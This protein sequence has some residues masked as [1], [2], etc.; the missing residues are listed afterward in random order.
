M[1]SYQ[2]LLAIAAATFGFV[3]AIFFCIGNISNSVEK[4]TL[5]STP[6][7]DFN[8]H[9]ARALAAQRAQYATGGLFLLVAFFF[10]IASALPGDAG[11]L[12]LPPLLRPTLSVTAALLLPSG[13]LG[14]YLC[15]HLEV[16]T[17]EQVMNRN[18]AYMA[19][20]ATK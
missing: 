7:W 4:I 20:V 16:K 8:E 12:T 3:A 15:R 13:V 2:T 14:W 5:Q 1:Y 6:F 10:Q 18:A 17:F 9:V 19:D 11:N